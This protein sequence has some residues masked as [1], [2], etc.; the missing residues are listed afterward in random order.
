DARTEQLKT[1]IAEHGEAA[2][3]LDQRWQA[4][5]ELVSAITTIRTALYDLVSQPEPDEEKRRAYQAQLVQL[6]AQLSQVRTSLPL[7]QTEVNAEVIAS[8]VADWTGIPVGQMLK[9]DIR[10]VMELPQ[11]LEARVIG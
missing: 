10:A 4:E 7:V 1:S 3:K 5:R 11:R 9:D 8:I 6:E 2:D